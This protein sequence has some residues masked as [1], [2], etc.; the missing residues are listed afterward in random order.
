MGGGYVAIEMAQ[1]FH[2]FGSRVTVVEAGPRI[3]GREDPDVASE[4]AR[5]L[6]QEGIEIV[7]N[8]TATAVQGISGDGVRLTVRSSVGLAGDRR[9]R[10]AGGAWVAYPT[11]PA[12]GS[13]RPE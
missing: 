6:T 10:L 5:I 2:R 1:A 7:P 12:L 8:T 4:L 13:T 11:P 3:M 9:Q